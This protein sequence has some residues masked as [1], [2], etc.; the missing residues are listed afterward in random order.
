MARTLWDDFAPILQTATAAELASTH[1]PCYGLGNPQNRYFEGLHDE[2]RA[3]A[4]DG[5][6]LILLPRDYDGGDSPVDQSRSENKK[7]RT[8]YSNW[9]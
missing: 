3:V 7:L 5:N 1:A 2:V 4:L 9:L 6:S 8:V